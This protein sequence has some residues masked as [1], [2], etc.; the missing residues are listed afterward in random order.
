MEL[1]EQLYWLSN[2]LHP[3]TKEKMPNRSL[4]HLPE[5]Q[6]YLNALATEILD[7]ED[8]GDFVEAV[9]TPTTKNKS[10][11]KKVKYRTFSAEEREARIAINI[12]KELPLRSHFPWCLEEDQEVERSFNNGYSIEEIAKEQKRSSGAIRSKLKNLGLIEE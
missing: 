11:K 2:G 7:L 1:S 12:E 9:P 8:V 5:V 6:R 3:T 4:T 10:S